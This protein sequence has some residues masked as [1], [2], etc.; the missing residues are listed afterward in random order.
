MSHKQ[1]I[2]KR[3]SLRSSLVPSHPSVPSSA[4]SISPPRSPGLC[5]SPP[6]PSF[7]SPFLSPLPPSAG[8]GCPRTD[9]VPFLPAQLAAP[10]ARAQLTGASTSSM[11]QPSSRSLKVSTGV[12]RRGATPRPPPRLAACGETWLAGGRAAVAEY[13]SCPP[14][15]GA[16]GVAKMARGPSAGGEASWQGV[17][18]GGLHVPGVVYVSRLVLLWFYLGEVGFRS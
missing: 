16:C 18:A 8:P 10:Q 9:C 6:P 1:G 17:A 15:C 5:L 12:P 7:P 4:P 13:G 2:W 11:E 3:S 14:G